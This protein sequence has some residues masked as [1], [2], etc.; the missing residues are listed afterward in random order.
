MAAQLDWLMAALLP[1]ERPE[2]KM[3][4][5][6]EGEWLFPG[7]LIEMVALCHNFNLR[8]WLETSSS[9]S[10]QDLGLAVPVMRSSW[11]LG[12]QLGQKHGQGMVRA[13]WVRRRGGGEHSTHH[14]HTT[15][16]CREMFLCH[17]HARICTQ[18]AWRVN[19]IPLSL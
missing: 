10:R 14:P 9:P 11:L 7:M 13:G 8:S 19:T 3:A 6:P 17:G 12:Q 18:Q 1:A 16:P 5:A 4:L 15:C 2:G